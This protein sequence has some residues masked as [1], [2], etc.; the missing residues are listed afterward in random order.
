MTDADPATDAARATTALAAFVVKRG[1]GLGRLTDDR[2]QAALV[3]AA[4]A[5]AL[6]ETPGEREA[7]DRLRDW[8]DG[9]AAFLDTDPAEL[10]RWLVDTGW[11]ARD[12]YGR[13]YRR[14]ATAALP[15]AAR[16]WAQALASAA[17]GD[18]PASVRAWALGLIE[19]EAAR[20]A[21]RRSAAAGS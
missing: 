4:A 13:A 8:L 9:P 18:T 16:P 1:V 14:V 15:E 17:A 10:R 12:G 6:D 7:S 11:W 5:I 20:R 3:V 19:A 2:R 21:A